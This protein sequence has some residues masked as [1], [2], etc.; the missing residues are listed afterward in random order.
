MCKVA[1][2]ISGLTVMYNSHSF[3]AEIAYSS[4]KNSAATDNERQTSSQQH[5]GRLKP[6]TSRL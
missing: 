2:L 5:C 3:V 6:S 1:V 4:S